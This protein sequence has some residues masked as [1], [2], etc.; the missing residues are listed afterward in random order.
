MNDV[1]AWV[2]GHAGDLILAA[3]ATVAAASA[4]ANLTPT[5]ADNKAVAWVAKVVNF[6]ALNWKKPA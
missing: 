5:D 3:T 6:L 2:V 4:I 1:V